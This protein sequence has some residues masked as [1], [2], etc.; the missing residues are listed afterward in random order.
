[1]RTVNDPQL[2]TPLAPLSHAVVQR[3]TVYCSGQLPL[4]PDGTMLEGGAGELTA[5]VLRNLESV[6]WAS[7]SSL[8]QVLRTTIYLVDLD[9]F[10]E[11]NRVYAELLPHAPARTCI[12]VAALPLGGR[13]E[14]DCIAEVGEGEGG[15]VSH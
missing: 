11:V 7:G 5:C 3:D 9:D 12:Q 1:M 14:I 6:L 8:D 15:R 2:S 10:A 13:V 4:R